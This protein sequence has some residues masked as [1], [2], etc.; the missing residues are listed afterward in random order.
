MAFSHLLSSLHGILYAL[1]N[2]PI[3]YF[4]PGGGK[5]GII[6]DSYFAEEETEV[7]GS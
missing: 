2:S 7:W 3:C 5:A 6:C 1:R 4:T